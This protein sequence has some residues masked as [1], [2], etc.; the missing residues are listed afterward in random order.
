MRKELEIMEGIMEKLYLKDK[1]S[2]FVDIFKAIAIFLV[3]L[4]HSRLCFPELKR[5]IYAFHMPAFFAA[6]GMTYNFERHKLKGFFNLDFIRSKFWRLI[7][8]CFL[9]AFIFS[10]LN[11]KNTAYILYGNYTG[12]KNAGSL[13]SL[14]Y[15][16]CFALAVC[17]FEILMSFVGKIKNKNIIIAF[18]AVI[19]ACIAYFLPKISFGYPW[20]LNISFMAFAFMAVGY[21]L[22]ELIIKLSFLNSSNFVAWI[23]IGI[24]SFAAVYFTYSINLNYMSTKN[25]EMAI[26]SYGNL[27]LFLIGGICGTLMLCAVSVLFN[28][29]PRKKLLSSIGQNTLI[30]Y[31]LHKPM[32]Y[33]AS[34][35]F[36]SKGINSGWIAIILSA[37]ILLICYVASLILNRYLPFL[38]GNY[39][40]LNSNKSK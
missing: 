35:A 15:L 8:P 32:I 2:T 20:S 10:E 23:I 17:L 18:A 19:S 6:Y 13:T 4:G 33:F 25:I 29:L 36:A 11:V 27:F 21:I 24:V 5:F 1:R 26:A 12:L 38:C 39:V 9:W 37:V 31:L 22:K 40:P 28:L 7:L 30:I 34:K 14:W 3:I 16:P